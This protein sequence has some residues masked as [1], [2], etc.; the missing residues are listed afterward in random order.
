MGNRDDGAPP[1]WEWLAQQHNNVDPR[2]AEAVR[3]V[4]ERWQLGP[5]YNHR[6]ALASLQAED[7]PYLHGLR[8]LT[9]DFVELFDLDPESQLR[10]HGLGMVGPLVPVGYEQ[11]T[12]HYKSGRLCTRDAVPGT[13]LCGNHGGSWINDDERAEM[14]TRVSAKLV[15]GAERAVATMLDLMDN[16]KS[17]K[18]R[19]DMAIALLDRIGVG[20]IQ[21]VELSVTPQAEEVAG[22]LK[23][24]ILELK[25]KADTVPGEVVEGDGEAESA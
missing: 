21:K 16:A 19:G 18:V 8:L 17:E 4:I 23:A 13:G 24:R 6:K 10:E 2:R 1:F 9:D 15:D 14:V 12:H 20:P 25:K 22:E 5:W 7:S 11:C 3:H